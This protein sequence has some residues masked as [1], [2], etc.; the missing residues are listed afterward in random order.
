MRTAASMRSRRT[1]CRA[2]RPQPHRRQPCQPVTRRQREQRQQLQQQQHSQHS[3]M[4]C[5]GQLQPQPLWR[6]SSLPPPRPQQQRPC[7]RAVAN[8]SRACIRS[9]S[10]STRFNPKLSV[11]SVCMPLSV[12]VCVSVYLCLCVC[13]CVCRRGTHAHTNTLSLSLHLFGV[14]Y[15]APVSLHSPLHA[16]FSLVQMDVLVSDGSGVLIA[17][18]SA[19]RAV[20]WRETLNSKRDVRVRNGRRRRQHSA[21]ASSAAYDVVYQHMAQ[22]AEVRCT[23]LPKSL[24]VCVCVCVCLC[25]Y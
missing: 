23:W 20:V 24:C 15:L 9:P 11:F 5:Q 25:V 22:E 8:R 12:C 13:V 10:C 4:S 6:R 17:A 14:M 7:G 16:L 19:R 2:P 18:W 21:D 1:P 3:S